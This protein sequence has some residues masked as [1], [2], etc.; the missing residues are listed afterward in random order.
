[1]KKAIALIL[2]LGC[3][4]AGIKEDFFHTGLS[5]KALALGGTA[6]GFGVDSIYSNPAG[7]AVIPEEYYG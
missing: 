1:M 7:L 6:F 5:A 4:L 3:S 2:L